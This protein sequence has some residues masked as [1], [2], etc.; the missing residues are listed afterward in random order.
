MDESQKHLINKLFNVSYFLDP[1]HLILDS[2]LIVDGDDYNRL[3]SDRLPSKFDLHKD[4]YLLLIIHSSLLFH[5]K[6]FLQKALFCLA[7]LQNF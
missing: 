7:K 1:Q 5:V 6:H 2:H 4:N 3:G